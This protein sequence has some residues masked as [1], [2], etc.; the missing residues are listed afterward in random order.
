MEPQTASDTNNLRLLQSN[1]TEEDIQSRS[2]D[3]QDLKMVRKDRH[4]L[5]ELFN[6]HSTLGVLSRIPDRSYVKA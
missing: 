2:T 6:Q 3:H 5:Q 4:P 1:F